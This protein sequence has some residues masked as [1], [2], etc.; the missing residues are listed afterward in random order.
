ML[1]TLTEIVKICGKLEKMGFEVILL[2]DDAYI[3]I[4]IP[5]E[6]KDEETLQTEQE[7]DTSTIQSDSGSYT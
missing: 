7:Q 1:E 3:A 6:K 4:E 5:V 2:V